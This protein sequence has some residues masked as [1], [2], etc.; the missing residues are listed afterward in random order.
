M[1]Y[2]EA[3]RGI[4]EEEARKYAIGIGLVNDLALSLK[5]KGLLPEEFSKT[6]TKSPDLII[7]AVAECKKGPLTP[8]LMTK[9]FQ[10]I[11]QKRG[12]SVGIKFDVSPCP[13]T[14]EELA[15]LE[16]KGLRLGYLPT[17]LA[18]RESRHILDK[19]FPKMQSAS[20]QEGNSVANDRNPS[21]WFDYEAGIDALYL[22]TT[23]EQ[24]LDMLNKANRQLLN[25]NQYIVAGQ[26]SKLFTG[27]YLDEGDTWVRV[28]SRLGGRLVGVHFY[29]DGGLSVRWSLYPRNSDPRLGGRSSG[30]N[31]A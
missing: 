29:S 20:V 7:S 5:A 4:P 11:W 23:E 18:T 26:D 10:A 27:R 22:G 8:E 16:E 1:N 17:A 28:G 25:E 13:F 12:E 19:I 2:R 24:L 6:G 3:S 9:T 30:V 21:S 15:G 14:K 31:R